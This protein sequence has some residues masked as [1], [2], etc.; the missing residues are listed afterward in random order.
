[1]AGMGTRP[2]RLENVPP[3]TPDEAVN[4]TFSQYGEVKKMQRETCYLLFVAYRYKVFSGVRIMVITLTKHIPSHKMIAG[5]RGLESYEG[6]PT[7]SYG[8]GETGH[9]NHVCPKRRRVGVETTKEP[10]VSWADKAVS[11]NMSPK[12]KVGVNEKEA[13]QQ[14]IQTGYGDENRAEDEEAMQEDNTNSTGLAS[15]QSEEP[16]RG[17]GGGSDV[18]NNAKT[19][20]VDG[21]PGVEDSMDCGDEILGDR[22]ATV[23][24]QPLLRQPQEDMS[25]TTEAWKEEELGRGKQETRSGGVMKDHTQPVEEVRTATPSISPKK[26]KKLE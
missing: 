2:M 10:K 26:T 9:F 17:T 22:N 7:T 5:H 24:C 13:D 25:T 21:R 14:S 4:F 15:E 3:E 12:T 23:K 18:R 20:C 1:M 11:G 6:Q 19:S 16:E 8:C